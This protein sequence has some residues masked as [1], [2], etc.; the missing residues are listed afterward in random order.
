[1]N[2]SN[3]AIDNSRV[4]HNGFGDPNFKQESSPRRV[5]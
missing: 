4:Q 5:V 2:L 1:M 3:R